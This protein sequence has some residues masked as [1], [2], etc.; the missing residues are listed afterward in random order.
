VALCTRT[1]IDA[2]L[3]PCTKLNSKFIKDINIKSDRPRPILEKVKNSL[4]CVVT[5][6][7]LNRPLIAQALKT[8]INK[9]N[10]VKLRILC[11]SS[12]GQ[13][14]SLQNWSRFLSATHLIK[15]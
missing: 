8:I 13:S 9:W 5:E 10:L 15:D 14:S 11:T 2:Y 7:F 4:E 3:S 6:D 12:F 1:Q